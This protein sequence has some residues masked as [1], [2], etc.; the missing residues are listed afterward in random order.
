MTDNP[1][2]QNSESESKGAFCD[3]DIC[4][5]TLQV[6][7]KL[8]HIKDVHAL[9]AEVLLQARR[10]TR[11]DAG[12]IYLIENNVLNFSYIHNDTLFGASEINR[13]LY[14]SHTLAVDNHSLSGYVALTGKPLLIEDAYHLPPGMPFTFNNSFDRMSGYRTQSILAAPL[15]TS[16]GKTVGVIQI[17]NPLNDDRQASAFTPG[18]LLL[19]KHFADNAAAAIER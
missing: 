1:A 16:N 14:T 8:A 12:S 3:K 7:E 2:S 19:L 17:I 13:Y 5:R 18:D 10:L 15:V 9:L 11:A 6:M 4:T